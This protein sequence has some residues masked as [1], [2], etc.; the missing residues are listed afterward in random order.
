VGEAAYRGGLLMQEMLV[1]WLSMGGYS[2]YVWPAYG[3]VCVA[4]V[5][6]LLGIR[7]VR[8]KT[9]KKLNRWFKRS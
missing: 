8:E 7:I 3:L 9:R 6:N 1:D 4:L 2:L 5:V